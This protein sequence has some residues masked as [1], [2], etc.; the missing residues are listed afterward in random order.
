M[1]LPMCYSR[2]PIGGVFLEVRAGFWRAEEEWRVITHQVFE[3]T[4]CYS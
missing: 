3:Q 2:T 1:G 4:F